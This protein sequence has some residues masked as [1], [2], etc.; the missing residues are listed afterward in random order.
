MSASGY[1]L[2]HR[3][4]FGHP[5]L[6]NSILMQGAWDWI[7]GNAN[8]LPTRSEHKGRVITLERGQL[9]GG[10]EYLAK[11]WGISPD[12][13]RTI[14]SKLETDG[15]I[16]RHQAPNHGANIITVCNY[17]KYQNAVA[18]E[19]QASP[20]AG[21]RPS[22][23]SPHNISKGKELK[24][25]LQPR[26]SANDDPDPGDVG[27][28]RPEF[29]EFV[30]RLH[31]AGGKALN[32]NSPDLLVSMLPDTWIRQ[33]ADLE[34][35]II[36]TITRISQKRQPASIR[37]WSYFSEPI[38][39]ARE[40]RLA[41]ERKMARRPQSSTSARRADPTPEVEPIPTARPGDVHAFN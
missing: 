37:T 19:P 41:L 11:E 31:D 25:E 38:I 7:I 2:S 5:L 20:Q 6:K 36:P 35:D 28:P 17:E 24:E 12:R 34:L 23:S 27:V 13:V 22:P 8:F 15:M 4:K 40:R 39:E 21:P 30:D 33:G 14:L 1:Y 3:R 10:R 9:L 32:P 18:V 26:A 29:A 16:K